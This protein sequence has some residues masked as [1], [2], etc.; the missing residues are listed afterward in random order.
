MTSKRV[1]LDCNVIVSALIKGDSSPGRAFDFVLKNHESVTSEDCLF[2]IERILHKPKFRRYFSEQE[3][4]I[5]L[6]V[7]KET[8]VVVK[9]IGD[10][11]V[12][13]D[14][15]D[16]MYLEAAVSGQAE[17]IITGDPDLLVLNPFRGINILTPHDFLLLF[18]YPS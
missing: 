11:S 6:E 4:G 10:I 8:A 16:D 5:F 12:C 17:Y 3:A 13:R 1:V 7:F 18:E 15:K 14:S 9:S 2:E